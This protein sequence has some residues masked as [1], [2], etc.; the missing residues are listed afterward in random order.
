[1]T[2]KVMPA[3]RSTRLG[4][5]STQFPILLYSSIFYDT[6]AKIHVFRV[7]MQTYRVFILHACPSSFA[8]L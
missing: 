2:D 6:S 4:K 3:C 7:L 5:S 1:M 8:I